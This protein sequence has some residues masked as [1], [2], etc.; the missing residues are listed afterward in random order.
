MFE[1]L[2]ELTD[3]QIDARC[4]ELELVD[5]YEPG[6]PSRD[7]PESKYPN[8]G[9]MGMPDDAAGLHRESPGSQLGWLLE[10]MNTADV[11]DYG[12]VEVIAAWERMISYATARQA[13]AIAELAD[14]P[15]MQGTIGPSYS[16]LQQ[17]RVTA[18]EI[19]AR[20]SWST[21]IA[22]HLVDQ[23]LLLT[24]P[25]SATRDALLAGRI[26]TRHA[27]V[28]A[29]E[30]GDIRDDPALAAR[31]QER[32]LAAVDGVTPT[33]LRSKVKRTLARLAPDRVKETIHRTAAQREVTCRPA[34]NGM[35]FLDAYLPAADATAFMAGLDAAAAAARLDNPD[36]QRTLPQ[37]RAD[38]L[39]EMGWTALATGYLTGD[40]SGPRLAS[41]RQGHPVTVNVTV[42]LT[43]L[44]GLD[45][46]SGELA[47]YG[48]IDA[49][50]AR[51]R[52]LRAPGG[53]SSPTRNRMRFLMLA[54]RRTG[55]RPISPITSSGAIA[56][57]LHL[58]AAGPRSH[59]SSITRC[60]IQKV[61]QPQAI[62]DCSA[63]GIIWSNTT[64]GGGYTNPSQ[65]NSSGPAPPATRT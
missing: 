65:G 1:S 56:I 15:C 21:G 25:L 9:V 30:L 41:T 12:L 35:A 60:P 48:P 53:D 43:T 38:A 18:V 20:L 55:H 14:R 40:P 17:E 45:E 42:A 32:V 5:P 6:E 11:S 24:G 49:D 63:G 3:E 22:D 37:L 51:R 26:T 52:P 28:I 29:D 36:D 33:M 16:S 23:A 39:A 61:R 54:A 57:A 64:L 59:A 19:G 10:R 46:Q 50:T 34:P 27:R 7:H 13:A 8:S 62:W 58:A 4:A 44:L 31:I 47:G 2:L